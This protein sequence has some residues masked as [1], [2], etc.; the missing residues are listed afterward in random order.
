MAI[1]NIHREDCGA[2]AISERRPYDKQ[3]AA[4]D[5]IKKETEEETIEEMKKS[6]RMLL[7]CKRCGYVIFSEDPPYA[8]PICQAKRKMF[9]EIVTLS[10]H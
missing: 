3:M 9:E 4:L 7:Y 1:K 2:R 10:G 6:S 8:C 5:H